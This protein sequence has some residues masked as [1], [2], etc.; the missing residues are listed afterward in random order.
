MTT[1]K[2][3]AGQILKNCYLSDLRKILKDNNMIY[4]LGGN[5]KKYYSK[6]NKR[7]YVEAIR[8]HIPNYNISHL[9]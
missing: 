1:P 8:Q 9:N 4:Y 2:Y 3:P 6:A 5:N 7:K